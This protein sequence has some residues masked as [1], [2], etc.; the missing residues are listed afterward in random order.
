MWVFLSARLRTWLLLAVAH[1]WPG[2]LS[3]S[4]PSPPNAVTPPPARKTAP[5][6]RLGSDRGSQAN[7]AQGHTLRPA[8]AGA[9]GGSGESGPGYRR[10]GLRRDPRI[11]VAQRG[12]RPARTGLLRAA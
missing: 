1:R 12:A 9:R 3:I 11:T 7:L 6:G 5:P 10:P 4:S 2:C 8:S